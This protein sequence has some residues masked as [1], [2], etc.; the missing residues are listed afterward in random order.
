M[1]FNGSSV[2]YTNVAPHV[3]LASFL[4]FFEQSDATVL[5]D[6]AL[7]MTKASYALLFVYW[8]HVIAPNCSVCM[9]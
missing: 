7:T 5:A 9:N 6:H 3:Q 1:P 8:R 4:Q 2:A